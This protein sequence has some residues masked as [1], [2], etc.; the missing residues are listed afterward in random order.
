MVEKNVNARIIHKHDTEENWFKAINFT[1]KR[2]ELIIY[3]PDA[4]YSYSRFKIGNGV[5]NINDLPFADGSFGGPDAI[6]AGSIVDDLSGNFGTI[7]A[8]CIM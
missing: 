3:D 8:E 5:T 4:T 1:P 7:D 6:D 2:G